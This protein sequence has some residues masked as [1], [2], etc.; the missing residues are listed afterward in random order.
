M[1]HRIETVEQE[2]VVCPY[3]GYEH[4]PTYMVE[5][6]ASRCR[7]CDRE[8]EVTITSIPLYT[9]QK[10]ERCPYCGIHFAMKDERR[11]EYHL[12]ASTRAQC[13]GSMRPDK[14]PKQ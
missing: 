11:F 1:N 2:R 10:V 9:T 6:G 8:F 14:R 7:S 5:A 12:N 13:P 4:G 3:C